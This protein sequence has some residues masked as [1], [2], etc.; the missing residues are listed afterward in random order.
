VAEVGDGRGGCQRRIEHERVVAAAAGHGVAAAD[1]HGV[2]SA[3]AIEHSEYR[4]RQRVVGPVLAVTES[5]IVRRGRI[6][7][8][9]KRTLKIRI[10]R[11]VLLGVE[12]VQRPTLVYAELGVM[13]SPG[14]RIVAERC[15]QIGGRSTQ[16]TRW[17]LRS[18]RRGVR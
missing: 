14:V 15:D 2:V 18:W 6:G 3:V 4:P 13:R 9:A 1:C 17:R 12:T 5:D 8:I 16:C 7:V 11:E 10:I